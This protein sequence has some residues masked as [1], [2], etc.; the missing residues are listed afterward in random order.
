MEVKTLPTNEYSR[1]VAFLSTRDV[2]QRLS[3]EIAP[4]YS[5]NY[6]YLLTKLQIE[7]RLALHGLDPGAE[8]GFGNPL[9][10]FNLLAKSG[11][12]RALRI[13]EYYWVAG[14]TIYGGLGCGCSLANLAKIERS[15]QSSDPNAV[16]YQR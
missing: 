11:A 3:F 2:N 12:L 8:F 5:L 6:L 15:C 14:R 13:G 1:V 9:P 4:G 16:Q 10:I 7:N